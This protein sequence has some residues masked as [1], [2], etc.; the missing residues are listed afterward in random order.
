MRFAALLA[1]VSSCLSSAS[2][3]AQGNTPYAYDLRVALLPIAFKGGVSQNHVGS[4]ARVEFDVARGVT[5][6]ATGRLPWLEVSGEEDVQE[7]TVR[8]GVAWHF[9]DDVEPTQLSGTVYP[10]DTG[11]MRGGGSSGTDTDLDVPVHQ[12]LGGPRMTLP[13]KDR[14]VAADVRHV[15]SLRLGWDFV[16]SVEWARPRT[17]GEPDPHVI[18]RLHALYLGYG[19]GSHWNLS[20]FETDGGREV[21]WR[22]FHVDAL[23]APKALVDRE[24]IPPTPPV[25]LDFFPLGLRMGMAGAICALVPHAHGLGFGYSIE[26][27]ALPGESGLEGYL[28]IGFGLELDGATRRHRR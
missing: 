22:R 9:V 24:P 12:K 13:E 16:R 23:L 28:F 18:N 2:A 15:Q 5:V 21:G 25:E 8:A 19:W 14:S 6:E 3:A 20:P 10:E 27:G 26:L 11:K 7:Y 4:A 17:T 1:L